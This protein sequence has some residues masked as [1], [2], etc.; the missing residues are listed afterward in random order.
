VEEVLARELVAATSQMNAS[1]ILYN[2]S[3]AFGSREP[4]DLLVQS[5][6]TGCY[7]LSNDMY[8]RALVDDARMLQRRATRTRRNRRNLYAITGIDHFENFLRI[9]ERLFESAGADAPLTEE[10]IRRCREAREAARRGEFDA[11]EFEAALEDARSAICSTLAELQRA[12]AD[13]R[14]RRRLARRISSGFTILC[15]CVVVGLDASVLTLTA[16]LSAAGAAASGAV[17]SAI[18][19]QGISELRSSD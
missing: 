14:R 9:E 13:E 19:G 2:T 11:Q 7:F 8:V 17:G 18:V 6:A 5:A 10:I 3:T 16:G 15:G 12:A 1:L 4:A